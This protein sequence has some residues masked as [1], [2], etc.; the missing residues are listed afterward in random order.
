M[1]ARYSVW[2]LVYGGLLAVPVAGAD[3]VNEV[4]ADGPVAYY[5][6]EESA[7]AAVM[8]DSSGN[9][10][11][12][13]EV[14]NVVFGASGCVGNAARFSNS[15]ARVNLQLDPSAGDFTIEALV[16]FK[17]RN[18]RH[19]LVA[20]KGGTGRGSTFLFRKND[21]KMN[22]DLGESQLFAGYPTQTERWYHVVLTVEDGSGTDTVRL[23]VDGRGRERR[24]GARIG[25]GI[26]QSSE[27]AA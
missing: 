13:E 24:L 12:S 8:V 22:S 16:R 25:P 14:S 15:Y 20:Q 7:G 5:R 18:G 17:P 21:G 9:G 19:S 26:L 11:G 23:Y 6:F 27:R 1:K 2:V 4:M 3:Y 10:H